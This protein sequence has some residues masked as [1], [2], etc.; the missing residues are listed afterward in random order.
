[1]RSLSRMV[2]GVTI[3][4][5]GC[6]SVRLV[7]RDGCW[8]KKTEGALG[9]GSEELGFCSRPQQP[10]AEDRLTRLVQ[11]CLAQADHRWENQAL[12]AWNHNRPIPA[13][14]EDADVVKTCMTHV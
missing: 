1:M 10:P 8:V 12:A 2:I 3:L 4:A 13:Q 6:T 5:V 9:G 11:E 14:A 7:Q